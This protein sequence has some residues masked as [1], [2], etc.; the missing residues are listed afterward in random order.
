[1]LWLETDRPSDA[2]KTRNPLINGTSQATKSSQVAPAGGEVRPTQATVNGV[3]LSDT[4]EFPP[5]PKL[6]NH[7][8][9]RPDDHIQ[10]QDAMD[11]DGFVMLGARVIDVHGGHHHQPSG[12]SP[13]PTGHQTDNFI[14]RD[15]LEE[16]H[17]KRQHV[18]SGTAWYGGAMQET[19]TVEQRYT[20]RNGMYHLP[21]SCLVFS[22]DY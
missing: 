6:S 22:H 16:S 20:S 1:M 21:H 9:A 18:A 14:S 3:E 11:L 2:A 15:G 19:S 17:P 8:I 10:G 13:M 5:I 4:D 12:Q 7:P